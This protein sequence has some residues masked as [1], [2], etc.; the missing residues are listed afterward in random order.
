M[1]TLSATMYR[2]HHI[3]VMEASPCNAHFLSSPLSEWTSCGCE[4]IEPCLRVL[5]A[6]G[7]AGAGH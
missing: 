3:L 7:G 4:P 1:E 6:G 5:R 2:S